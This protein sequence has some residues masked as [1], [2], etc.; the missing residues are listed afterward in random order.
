MRVPQ[1]LALALLAGTAPTVSSAKTPGEIP[2]EASEEALAEWRK[3]TQ[4]AVSDIIPLDSK[5]GKEL[6]R[7]TGGPAYEPLA[8]NWVPQLKSH[9]GAASAVVVQNAMLPGEDF[10]QSDLFTAETAHI[11]TQDVVYRIGFTLEELDNMIETRSGLQTTRFHAGEE[12]GMFGYEDWLA[13]LKKNQANPDNHLII[14]YPVQFM[15]DRQNKGGHFSPI[16]AYNEE[17][18]LVL[19]LEINPR[20]GSYWIDA[21]EVWEAMNEV[22]SVSELARGWIVVEQQEPEE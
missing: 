13:A 14:N 12:D 9:C 8:A 20:R 22:D 10:T 5:E 15:F 17:K 21:R 11:I 3:K 6:L 19:I 4:D 2:V 18:N 16:A 7:E 1:L